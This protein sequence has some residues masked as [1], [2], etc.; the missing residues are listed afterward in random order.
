MDDES[1]FDCGDVIRCVHI[2][3]FKIDAVDVAIFELDALA[4]QLH[5]TV[6]QDYCIAQFNPVVLLEVG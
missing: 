2:I 4:M 5:I 3:D 1:P 6:K